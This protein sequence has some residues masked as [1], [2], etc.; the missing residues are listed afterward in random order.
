[1]KKLFLKIV[2][3]FLIVFVMDFAFGVVMK[4]TL[5]ATKKGD[6]GRRNY[7]INESHEDILIFGSSR[8]IHHYD[9]QILKDSLNMTC[10]NCAEEGNGILLYYPVIL[11]ILQRYTPKVIIYD[12]IPKYDFLKYGEISSLGLLRPYSDRSEVHRFIG[13]VESEEILKLSSKFYKYNSSFME[14]LSQRFSSASLTAEQFSY[15]PLESELKSEPSNLGF[16]EGEGLDSTKFYYLKKL[17]D[18]CNAKEVKLY[19]ITSPWYKME[20][21]DVYYPIENICKD[22]NVVFF[23]HNFDAKFNRELS[24]FHDAAHMSRKGAEAFSSVIAHEIKER[25]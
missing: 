20:Y 10:F 14:I 24:Y 16:I 3:F 23:N 9:P 6:W 12:L 13:E 21:Q 19:F 25:K 18:L 4:S 17:V 15:S 22:K 5:A 1:M 11:S 7:I 8:A 2:I